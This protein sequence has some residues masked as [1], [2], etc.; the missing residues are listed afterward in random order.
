MQTKE[1]RTVMSSWRPSLSS[2]RRDSTSVVEREISRP[3][4]YRSWK[5]TLSACAC[6]KMRPRRSSRTSW[7][8]RAEAMMK[9]YWRA[10]EAPA[11]SR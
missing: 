3:D 7:L 2:S 10:P 5:S 9:P 6:R 8:T 1:S 4:V 11:Q